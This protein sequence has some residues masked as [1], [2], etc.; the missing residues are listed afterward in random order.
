[1]TFE[2]TRLASLTP[3]KTKRIQ[4]SNPVLLALSVLSEVLTAVTTIARVRLENG[5][6]H[7]GGKGAERAGCVLSPLKFSPKSRREIR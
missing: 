6:V 7:F 4:T 2:E 1:M 5:N 3:R